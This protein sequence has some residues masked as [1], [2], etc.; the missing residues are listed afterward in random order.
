[1]ETL[2]NRRDVGGPTWRLV[3]LRTLAGHQNGVTSVAFTP[4][5]KTLASG[6]LLNCPSAPVRPRK[7]FGSSENE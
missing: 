7:S 2:L 6:L 1:M 5:G 4:D 3:A